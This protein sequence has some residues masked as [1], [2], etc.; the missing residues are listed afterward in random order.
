MSVNTSTHPVPIG[1]VQWVRES[2]A[3]PAPMDPPIYVT[4]PNTVG[5]ALGPK[6]EGQPILVR[7]IWDATRRVGVVYVVCSRQDHWLSD[8]HGTSSISFTMETPLTGHQILEETDIVDASP[9][10][11][12]TK[13]NALVDEKGMTE[14]LRYLYDELDELLL[15]QCFSQCDHILRAVDVN[16]THLKILMGYMTITL[17][18]RQQLTERGAFMD[19]VRQAALKE[20]PTARV[21]ALLKGLQ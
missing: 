9:A 10:L 3:F 15:A 13:V 16:N 6:T 5:V 2:A 11:M 20:L 18:W 21:D 14:A 19:R 4:S 12:V 1:L 17:P 7:H 8:I